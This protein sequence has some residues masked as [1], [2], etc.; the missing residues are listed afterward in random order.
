MNNGESIKKYN[1]LLIKYLNDLVNDI[2]SN[3]DDNL[4]FFE[5]IATRLVVEL[6][7]YNINIAKDGI[8]TLMLNAFK[9]YSN[10]LKEH[11]D[12]SGIHRIND[13]NDAD[14]LITEMNEV[15]VN[16]ANAVTSINKIHKYLA[17]VEKIKLTLI[18]Y[19]KQVN[20]E[21]SNIEN[22]INKVL[23]DIIVDSFNAFTT[24][25]INDFSTYTLPELYIIVD[26]I[27]KNAYDEIITL[28]NENYIINNEDVVAERDEF[29]S[30][31]M[32]ID[33]EEG[34]EDGVV[35][36]VVIDSM[37]VENKYYGEEAMEKLTSYNQLF[38]S[39][40]PG[41]K[42]D[43]SHWANSLPGPQKV[44]NNPNNNVDLLGSPN[45]ENEN[46]VDFN[47]SNGV[48]NSTFSDSDINLDS[49]NE[50]SNVDM[51]NVIGNDENY[52]IG[53]ATLTDNNIND[54]NS[55]D[56]N[57]NDSSD[58]FSSLSDIDNKNNESEKFI[59][60]FLSNYDNTNN[61]DNYNN[62]NNVSETNV[63]DNSNEEF[64][65]LMEKQ[66]S[67]DELLSLINPNSSKNE[68]TNLESNPQPISSNNDDFNNLSTTNSDIIEESDSDSLGEVRKIMGIENSSNNSNSL[69]FI[70][71]FDNPNEDRDKFIKSTTGILIEEDTDNKGLLYLKVTEPTGREQIFTGKE[72]VSM[73]KNYNKIYLEANPDASVDTSLIE[74]FE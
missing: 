14:K 15:N 51:N 13:S 69:S 57:N 59:Q 45:I 72:A 50:E 42:V 34:F 1:D 74:G 8:K 46:I 36:L 7:N 38:E 52:N 41:K 73:I 35:T 48:E 33:I 28:S 60:N 24:K 66:T 9:E 54:T 2:A 27:K 68:F 37:G 49:N 64:N 30:Q 11:F 65:N 25:K 17:L 26:S 31:T 20:S 6:K 53:V 55:L 10:I 4:N 61:I 40:R 43:I 71:T 16:L 47:L 29:I 32:D 62:I 3:S 12:S 23:D 44:V 39:S 63:V 58:D 5:D 70:P 56:I 19:F 18:A 21:Y 22:N 67:N